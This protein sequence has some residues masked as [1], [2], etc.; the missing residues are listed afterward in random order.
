MNASCLTVVLIDQS[1][2]NLD[3][4]LWKNTDAVLKW[5]QNIPNKNQYSFIS[6][7]VVD[8]YQSISIDLL[9]AALDFASSYDHITDEE[10]EI[11]IHAKKSCLYN[12]GDFWGKRSSTNLFD[13]TMGSY[14]GAETC[15]LVEAFLLQ[16]ITSKHGNNFGLYR[17][18][19][20]G[21][22]NASARVIENVKK[23]LCAIFNQF[24]LKITIEANMKIIN[25]LDVTLNL[26]TGKYQPYS[27]PNNVPLYVNSKSNHPP[28]ILR[29]IPLSIN[30]RL[31]QISSDKDSFN[32]T[33]AEY[34]RAIDSSGYNHK[35]QFV[36]PS[37]STPASKPKSRKRKITWYN[38]LFSKNVKTNIGQ[39]FLKI[40]DEEFPTSNPLHKIFNRNT[41]KIS[42]CCMPNIKQTLDG[43]NKSILSKSVKPNTTA[44]TCNCRKANECMS[45]IEKMLN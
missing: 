37:L 1:R 23:D 33:S 17:D 28:N 18:D 30:K 12:S 15:E 27:K 8:F 3:S 22:M 39:S 16:H 29:N 9:N 7:D 4:S 10:R 44:I 43:H 32:N 38:P 25:F 5:F 20:L 6:F 41:L 31:S 2:F 14:D 24:G 11:I 35:L 21:V 34:Q 13:V 45:L 36:H 26:S 42:Y 40:I 19:G